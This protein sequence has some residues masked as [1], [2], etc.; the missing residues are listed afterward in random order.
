MDKPTVFISY[1]HDSDTHREQVLALSE[2]LRADGI[3]TRLDQYINGAPLEGWPRW[4]LN[5]LDEANFVLVV[6]TE[7]YYRRFRGKE[8][9]GKGKGADWEGA[10]ITQEIYDARSATLKFV[11]V[12]FAAD[13]QAFIPEPI[14]G[15]T[16][17][18]LTSEANYQALYDFLLDQSGV[19]PGIVGELKRKPRAK[20]QPLTFAGDTTSSPQSAALKP[21]HISI[22]RLPQLLTRD[23]FGRDAELKLLDD[24]WANPATNIVVFAAFGGTGKSALVNN[25]VRRSAQEGYRGAARVYAWSFWSQG[26]DQPQTSAD[27]FIDAALRWFDD[28]DPTAGSPWDKGER[29]ARHIKQTRTLLVL[30]G[31]EPLQHP[32]GPLEGQ[33]KEQT[34]QALLREL[35]AGQPGLCVI[36]TR[37]PIADLIDYDASAV[38]S[39]DLDQLSPQSGAQ[40]LRE[41]KI[42]GDEAELEQA[43]VDFGNHAL[44]LTILGSLLKDAYGG[45]IRRRKE[46]P[47]LRHAD[48]RKGRHALRVMASYEKWLSEAGEH[49][50]LAVLRLVGLFNRPAEAASIAALRAAPAIPGLTDALRGL[51]EAQWQQT[52]SK[53]RRIKLLAERPAQAARGAEEELDA[54]ALVREHF[55][56]QL[57]E[58]LPNAWREANNRIYEHLKSTTKEL[59]ETV[60]EMAPLFAA[61]AHGCG[62][63]RHQEALDDVYWPRIQRGKEYF[64]M[65]KLGAFG[66]DLATLQS[67]FATPWHEP[68]TYLS[69]TDQSYVL[70]IA[71]FDLWALGRLRAAAES[72]QAGLERDI[73]QKDWDGAAIGASNLSQIYL[74]LGE[75]SHARA[76]AQQSVELAD[77]S[78]DIEERIA[79]RATLA[80]ALHQSGHLIEA[81]AAFNA[82]EM[83]LKEED[84]THSIPYTLSGFQYFDFLLGRG[85]VQEVRSRM[86]KMI[87]WRLLA[88]SLLSIALNKL[89]LG[90]LHLLSKGAD[91]DAA[92]FLSHAVDGLRR[93]GQL[94]YIPLGLLAR[95]SLHRLTGEYHLAQRNLAEAHR[96]AE[97]GAMGLHLA[98]CHLEWARLRL[99]QGDPTRARAHWATAKAMIERMGYHRRDGEVAEIEQQLNAN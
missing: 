60:E 22:A 10:L 36:S 6:C 86:E 38:I 28:P 58:R 55:G 91:T 71:G 27:P 59:P 43:S 56:Q 1:S 50:M 88:D 69:T 74:T 52:L 85:R 63:G 12:L 75:L 8:E 92:A 73:F 17:Y 77:Q 30:D 20:A 46:I 11:P 67:F 93:A 34:M 47:A 89:T 96:I 72:L 18:T 76:A 29:L 31:L 26:S 90:R 95:A 33:L 5:Q 41:Q 70:S 21:Q 19:E 83:L 40:I 2:R 80:D 3:A 13:Q 51:S 49:A 54:H 25:W 99:A 14:R 37:E 66:A 4:M 81:E 78:G 53:L 84:P 79:N 24:A 98:D 64:L 44:A 68:L 15:G 62:A 57:R 32:P 48:D 16:Y 39:H 23:L 65:K 97:R 35:A 42:E 82:T 9:P 45:D 87:E 7:T 61:I 94:Q